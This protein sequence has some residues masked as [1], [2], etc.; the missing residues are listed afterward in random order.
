MSIRRV[1]ENLGMTQAQVAKLASVS[2]P[3]VS[4]AENG[5]HLPP[6]VIPAIRR[7]LHLEIV[8]RRELMRGTRLR[9][10][11][12]RSWSNIGDT[13]ATHALRAAIKDRAWW[14]L[15]Q[16]K[17]LEADGLLAALPEADGRELLDEYFP[18]MAP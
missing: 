13:P 15:E 8:R 1:R 3:H 16:N 11:I 2:A 5:R 17:V 4:A 9:D 7:A 6:Y 12:E 10:A 14:M 18:E